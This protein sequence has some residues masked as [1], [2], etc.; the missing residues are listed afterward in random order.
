MK[1]MLDLNLRLFVDAFGKL[2]VNVEGDLG[3]I[4]IVAG[5]KIKS[6]RNKKYIF[7]ILRVELPKK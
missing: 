1:N 6:L 3:E 4:Y 5:F 2:R 7:P